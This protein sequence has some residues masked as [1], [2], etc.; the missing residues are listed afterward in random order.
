MSAV[1]YPDG[2]SLAIFI[3]ISVVVAG[4]AAFAAGRFLAL[5]WRPLALGALYAGLIAA[6]ARF[7]HFALFAEPLVS[8]GRYAL[9]L[10]AALAFLVAGFHLTRRRLLR[11]QYG[12]GLPREAPGASTGASERR[13]GPDHAR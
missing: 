9:D 12:A 7:L 8:P 2:R 3:A 11:R 10:A 5:R 13:P 6:A 1:S 4:A